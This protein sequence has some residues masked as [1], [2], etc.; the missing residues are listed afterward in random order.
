[1]DLEVFNCYILMRSDMKLYLSFKKSIICLIKVYCSKETVTL[2]SNKC[3]EKIRLQCI[4]VSLSTISDLS[5]K[6]HTA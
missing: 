3:H 1:M 2:P 5:G 6:N 4:L